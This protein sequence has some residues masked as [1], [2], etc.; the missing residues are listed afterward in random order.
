MT[1]SLHSVDCGLVF[2]ELRRILLCCHCYFVIRKW[3]DII[4]SS[5]F[6][7]WYD[8]N[9]IS[10]KNIDRKPKNVDIEYSHGS[11]YLVSWC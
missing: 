9:F 3:P 7:V 11:L 5:R 8:N 6:H 4:S 1:H 2:Y 10:N